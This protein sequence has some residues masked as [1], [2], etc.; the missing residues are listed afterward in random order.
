MNLIA[1]AQLPEYQ[2]F[3]LDLFTRSDMPFSFHEPL[4][5]YLYM[6]GILTSETIQAPHGEFEEICRF[7]SAFVQQCL[8]HALSRALLTD[9]PSVLVLDPL[10]DLADVFATHAFNL[11]ALLI[12]YK[13]YLLR[14]KAKGVNPWKDQPRRET[15]LHLTEAVGHFHLFSWLQ[16]AVGK[17]CVV[18]P[19]FPTGNGK[20]D[21][22]L[23]CGEKRG[24]IEIKSFVDAYQAKFDRKQAAQYA[25]NLG[26]DTV[27][28][29]LFVPLED[30][31]V[32]EKLS[33]EEEIDG[34]RVHVVA[35]GWV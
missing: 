8:Y 31:A 17:R 13:E 2:G 26:F 14:L 21:I 15:D 9:N 34:V 12:R 18:S 25:E 6:N 33:G 7:S 20:V 35:I 11:P 10:D 5:N 16:T 23:R 24:I 1:K 30:E 28:L 32:L 27:T 3:L 19:E 4:H 22:H 29:A